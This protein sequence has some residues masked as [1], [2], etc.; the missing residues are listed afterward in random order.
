M[1]SWRKLALATVGL[2]AVIAA[3]R[4]VA[5]QTG[6]IA[7][8][9][10]DKDTKQPIGSVTVSVQATSYGIQTKDNGTYS[11]LGVPPGTYT[12][13]AKRVGY[14]E[15]Q[16]AQVNVSIDVRREINITMTSST[17]TLGVVKVDAPVVPIVEQGVMG[18]T[19]TITNETIAAL[20]VT[21]ISE[22]LALQQGYQEVPQNTNLISLAEERRNTTAPIRS[23]G[24]RGGSTITLVDGTPIN[25]VIF[26][27]QIITLNPLATSQVSFGLGYMDPQYGGGLAGIINQAVR[28]GG[29]RFT[30]SLQYQTSAIA[31]V[32]GS[33]PDELNANHLFQGFIS[34]P[35]PGTGNQLRYSL[36]GQVSNAKGRVLKFDNDV[37]R[38]NQPNV[39]TEQGSPQTL[40]I[41]QGWRA[42][43]GNQLSQVV[44]KVTY[45]PSASIKVSLSAINQSAEQLGFDRRYLLTYGGNEYNYDP[46]SRVST[47]MDTLGQSGQRNY[48]TII[49][50]SVRNQS[51]LYSANIEKRAA[52]S[53]I[54]ASIGQTGIKSV[55][56]NIWQGVCTADRYW[57]GNFTDAYINPFTP[58]GM[59]YG[60]TDLY[61][62][63]EDYTTRNARLDYASQLTD[64]HKVLVGAS[65]SI[66]DI[67]YKMVTGGGSN[68]GV[69]PTIN[70]IYRAKPTEI[71]SYLQD[72]IEYDFLTINVGVR[73]DYGKAQGKGFTNPLNATNATTAR[74]VCNG[75]AP[76]IS[77]SPFTFN[78]QTGVLACLSSPAGA[79]GKPALLDSA[80]KLAQVDDF[81][82]AKPRTAFS[83]R[84]GLSFPLTEQ[85]SMW[86][87]AGR[88]TQNPRY[89][90][91]YQNTGVGT[92]AGPE[93]GFC[94]ANAV[95]PGTTEC[96]PPLTFNNPDFIGNPNLLLEQATSYEVGYSANVGR[97]YAVQVSV[98]NRDESGLTGIRAND[99]VQDIGSTY[100]GISLPQYSIVVNQDFL[101]NRGIAV[102][103]D[104]SPGRNSVWGYNIN[105]GWERTTE[106]S[107]PPDRQN[108]AQDAGELNQGS[109]LRELTSSG[110]R[111]HSFNL[112][113]TLQYR[114]NNMPKIWGASALRNS[115]V[116]L[117]YA[118]ASGQPYTPNRNNNNSGGVV[119][120][121]TQTSSDLFSGRG[122]S[123]Q[124]ASLRYRKS[125]QIGNAQYGLL[126]TVQNI[127]NI[128]N[129]LQVYA[130]T[131][132]CNTGL[133]EFSQRR[134][135]NSSGS[136]STNL[137][138]PE[139]RS[140]GRRFSTGITVTF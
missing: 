130:N 21:S 86:F 42:F 2:I 100:N 81:K 119:T 75:T 134:V 138:Q 118:W 27:S 74:E 52:R 32:L 34:G 48:S 114:Q 58:V 60:A 112:T 76:G 132:D 22:V 6:S 23:R 72:N 51:H 78:G 106:N 98:F 103:L 57:R 116:G 10:T 92:V 9:V 70:Q 28:E 13:I 71:A 123:T 63:G 110:D 36:A 85:S 45:V 25:N 8:T 44:G 90:Y 97:N 126:V 129:C 64:H 79:N 7:G 73:Y 117:T 107:P 4:V 49:Q 120:S 128:Q 3:P 20:P 17:T 136:S 68:S 62:G 111:S 84:I 133:R 43:G 30:G 82:E 15:T 121:N 39:D 26:G 89:Q 104:R 61:Y 41:E 137:D 50:G 54:R 124:S 131:G 115:S 139:F 18:T 38:F 35:V 108:E 102:R 1:W 46:W 95:K 11:I 19:T 93:D 69:A 113:L 96:H 80:A 94:A 59:P 77:E 109:T 12:V 67:L 40:D 14:T 87:N 47:L 88:Y 122:P 101:T 135:G 91:V 33:R 105:Y 29:E 66:H 127:F 37:T 83:P 16:V 99:A 55:Q 56:C 31:G 140:A 53:Y 125:L 24:S 65:Y 5:A